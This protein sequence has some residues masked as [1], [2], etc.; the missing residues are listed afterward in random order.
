MLASTSAFVMYRTNSV[1][2]PSA[3]CDTISFDPGSRC[4]AGTSLYSP[5][6]TG[7]YVFVVIATF[8]NAQYLQAPNNT[9]TVGFGA[10]VLPFYILPFSYTTAV[11]TASNNIT[12][13][14]VWLQQCSAGV[15]LQSA[16]TLSAFNPNPVNPATLLGT[17]AG[18]GLVT[19]C[20]GYQIA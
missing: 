2:A 19:M 11:V 12:F 17:A 20:G 1:A 16:A 10:S 15:S 9:I 13:T 18:L 5:P 7:L 14:R 3:L 8:S 6:R 4:T